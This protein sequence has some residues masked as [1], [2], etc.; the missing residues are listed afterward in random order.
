MNAIAEIYGRIGPAV[1]TLPMLMALPVAAEFVQHAVEIG[2]GMYAPGGAAAAAFSPARMAAGL[3]K[4]LALLAVLVLLLRWWSFDR[5]LARAGR[6]GVRFW[7]GFVILIVVQVAA[8]IAIV[9]AGRAILAV[10]PDARL[11]AV[12]VPLICWLVLATV[13]IPW[14][15]ALLIEDR[16][17][18]L[19]RAV[20]ATGARLPVAFG[21]L[22]AGILPLMAAHYALG[23]G[24]MGR[25]P[26]IVWAM[27]LV[28]AGVVGL[29][30]VAIASTYFTLYC[31]AAATSA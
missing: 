8:Q 11:A 28:D 13:L 6:L 29:L 25:P 26:A 7:R 30:T 1:R 16:T 3:I 14:F 9:L 17:M 5:S 23:Y 15:V 12:L 4:V 20:R 22:I 21:I 2:V 27:M 19:G 10:A 24:A 31:R 18:T